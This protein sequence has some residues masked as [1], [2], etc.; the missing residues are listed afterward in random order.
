MGII[1]Y[2]L[3]LIQSAPQSDS[4]VP[5]HSIKD[6]VHA[7]LDTIKKDIVSINST[8][9][10]KLNKP[11]AVPINRERELWVF[12]AC[13]LT[14]LL[15][16]INRRINEKNHDQ[17]IIGFLRLGALGRSTT[18]SFFEFNI[19]Q[20]LAFVVHNLIVAL[21]VFYFLKETEFKFVDENM[22]FFTLL[23]FLVSIIYLFKFFFQYLTLNILQNDDLAVLLVKCTISLGYLVSLI[24]LPLFMVIYYSQLPEW[25][26]ILI[27][28]FGVLIAAYLLFRIFKYILLFAQF[29][30]SSA[31]YNIIYLC[32]IE[33]IPLLV[34]IKISLDIFY[35]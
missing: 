8:S 26:G 30:N 24:S 34:F 19:H 9:A 18:R 20:I 5:L 23:F 22:L 28:I 29:F 21:W 11:E 13:C 35:K 16:G 31:F 14:F 7:Q 4:T 33:L 3:L 2:L 12:I 6:S 27:N 17:S 25:Q 10:L 1:L 15:A 32:S